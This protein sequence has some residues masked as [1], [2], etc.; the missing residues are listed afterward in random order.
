MDGWYHRTRKGLTEAEEKTASERTPGDFLY[1][2]L[3]HTEEFLGW[4]SEDLPTHIFWS[5][6]IVALVGAALTG[7]RTIYPKTQAYL[8]NKVM[9]V[10][11]CVYI[12]M[13]IVLFFA[14]GRITTMPLPTG[15]NRMNNYGCCAQGLAYPHHKAEQLIGWY[16][17]APRIG[18]LGNEEAVGEVVGVVLVASGP[19]TGVD[20]DRA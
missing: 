20:M 10:V 14:S 12:P 1:L 4:N 17:A 8:T 11:C 15:V 5:L 9:L 6:V 18:R 13:L 2:R 19:T 3:F 7:L 16:D